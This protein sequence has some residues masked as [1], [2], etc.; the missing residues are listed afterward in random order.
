MS[1]YLGKLHECAV[2]FPMTDIWMDSCG[3]EELEYGLKRGIV[4]ATSNPIIVGS[5]VKEEMDIW[6]P[7]IKELIKEMPQAT[8]DEIAWH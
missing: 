5:V 6:E 7:R 4:G 2:K 1:E 8:E 3:E